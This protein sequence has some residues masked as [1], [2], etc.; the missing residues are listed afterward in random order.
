M[1]VGVPEAEKKPTA[2]GSAPVLQG[3]KVGQ[4]VDAETALLLQA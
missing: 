3:L 1:G 4:L 2:V